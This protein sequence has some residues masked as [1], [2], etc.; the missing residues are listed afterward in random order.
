MEEK[1]R[2]FKTTSIRLPSELWELAKKHG[3][4]RSRACCV[5]IRFLLNRDGIKIA[6]P[7]DDSIDKTYSELAEKVRKLSGH[8]DIMSRKLYLAELR[9]AADEV[10]K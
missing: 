2:E 3:I 5:G 6:S 10:E 7:I 8:L 4:G 9:A 1:K